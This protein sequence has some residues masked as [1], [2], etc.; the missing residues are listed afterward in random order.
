MDFGELVAGVVLVAAIAGL[1]ILMQRESRAQNVA[2]LD[3]ETR[4]RQG[5]AAEDD[6]DLP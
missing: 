5:A 2:P 1:T 3:A 4:A 6:D